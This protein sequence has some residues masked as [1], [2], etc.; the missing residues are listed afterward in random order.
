MKEAQDKKQRIIKNAAGALTKLIS[1]DFQV[2]SIV[3]FF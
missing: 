3:V 1:F 2:F